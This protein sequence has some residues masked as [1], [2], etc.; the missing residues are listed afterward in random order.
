MPLQGSCTW[1]IFGR[2]AVLGSQLFVLQCF[3]VCWSWWVLRGSL[4]V[5]M[6]T[7][8]LEKE[9]STYLNSDPFHCHHPSENSAFSPYSFHAQALNSLIFWP[10]TYVH[11][12]Y[13]QSQL[14]FIHHC[15]LPSQSWGSPF[16]FFCRKQF[17]QIHNLIGGE[18]NVFILLKFKE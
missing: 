5:S 12:Y 3:I 1:I 10:P 14:S 16:P 11:R 4:I 8:C 6:R 17:L 7:S 2:Y 13:F 15:S 9:T 18:E